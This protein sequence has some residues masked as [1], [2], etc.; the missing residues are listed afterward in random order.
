MFIFCFGL[1]LP[2]FPVVPEPINCALLA[3]SIFK[4]SCA[5]QIYLDKKGDKE[6]E[7]KASQDADMKR[8]R[9]E[10]KELCKVSSILAD[11]IAHEKITGKRIF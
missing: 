5:V 11:H 6:K 8:L 3:F 4:N 2:V 1:F 9:A 10:L 7:G